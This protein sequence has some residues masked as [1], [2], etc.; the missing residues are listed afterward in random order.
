MFT[1]YLS[2]L[3]QDHFAYIASIIQVFRQIKLSCDW[4]LIKVIQVY[5]VVNNRSVL[6][7]AFAT[8]SLKHPLSLIKMARKRAHGI[9]PSETQDTAE[10]KASQF[11]IIPT[12]EK[13]VCL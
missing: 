7:L 11:N 2:A 9:I 10:Q 5:P 1:W 4:L 13:Y 3:H 6:L 8:P 12:Y